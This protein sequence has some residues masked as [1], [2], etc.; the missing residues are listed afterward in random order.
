MMWGLWSFIPKLT[1]RYIDPKSAIV[2]EVTGGL[3]FVAIA[4]LTLKIQPVLHVT[5]TPLAIAT[6]VLGFAG[7]FMFLLA[8]SQGPVTLVAPISALYPLVSS[9]LAV[10]VLQESFS[11]QQGFGIGLAVIAIILMTT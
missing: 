6:G 9:L 11:L 1:T 3:V 7:A 10:M 2:Y 5:G 8:V 4:M